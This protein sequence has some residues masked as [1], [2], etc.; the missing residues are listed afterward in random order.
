MKRKY[1]VFC[2]KKCWY[3]YRKNNNLFKGKNN[4]K[5]KEKINIIC[6][7]C[8]KEFKVSLC[9]KN[10]KFCSKECY[11]E[12]LSNFYIGKNASN[13]QGGKSFE[14]YSP[15]FNQQLKEKVRVRD[16]F[17]C[18]LCG[19]PELEFNK[20]LCIHHI[21][22]DKQNNNINNLISLCMN[23]H[24]KTNGDR[25]YWVIFFK[26]LTRKNYGTIKN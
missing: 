6:K 5:W 17:I 10:K 2:S 23:C 26:K 21:D 25:N 11:T 3:K 24:L 19:I 18:Q 14:E 9:N 1:G 22:Y 20:R 16:N 7:S 13:W 15:L 12:G 8:K 4:S